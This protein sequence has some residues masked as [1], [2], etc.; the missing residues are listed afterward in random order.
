MLTDIVGIVEINGEHAAEDA[1]GAEL[2]RFIITFIMGW[3]IWSDVSQ[4]IAWFETDDLLQ[5]I[6]MLFQIVCMLW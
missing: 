2:M 5:R 1:T 3:R 6:E 4:I